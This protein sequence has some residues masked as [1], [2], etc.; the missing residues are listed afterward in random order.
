MIGSENIATIVPGRSDAD[1]ASDLRKRL[2]AA[3]GQVISLMD[4]GDS[5]GLHVSFQLGRNNFGMN[6]INELSIV[7]PL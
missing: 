5:S 7:R 3:L 6:H 2:E 4:E 1:I